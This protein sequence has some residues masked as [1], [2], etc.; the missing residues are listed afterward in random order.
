[1]KRPRIGISGIVRAV[2]GQPRTGVNAG[3]ATS[4]A[5]AG[6]IPLVL[7]P[8]MGPGAAA[9][10]LEAAHG[11]LLTGGEDLDPSAYGGV[12]NPA[13]GSVDP[14][15]DAFDFALFH[16][17]RKRRMPILA[18]CRGLQLANVA[19]GGTLWQDLP[20]QRPSKVTHDRPEDRRARIHVVAA[21]P[22]SRIHRA[23]G[24]E[25]L[26]VNSMHHQ[27]I[28]ELGRGLIASARADDDVI[29][30][31]ESPAG[32]WWLIGVQ[33]HPEE[34]HA[35][36]AAPDHGLFAALVQEAREFREGRGADRSAR[37]SARGRRERVPGR[38]RR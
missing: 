21:N 22:G 20:S 17:A 5:R 35:D 34:F 4:V 25:E 13:W 1:V 28:R 24:A 11:L 15:R 30:G 32:S 23:L 12:D 37:V 26:A 31:I 33:W 3:Y 36:G 38:S 9:E 7:T 16:A 6:G 29:E 18:V 10:A 8:L 19:L 14:E 27:A 2:G